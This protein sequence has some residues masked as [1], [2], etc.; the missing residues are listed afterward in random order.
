MGFELFRKNLSIINLIL[1]LW[2]ADF[3]RLVHLDVVR[4][5]AVL[6]SVYFPAGEEI[7]IQVE[8]EWNL[9]AKMQHILSKLH[10][11]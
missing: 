9:N 5:R 4:N 2:L 6:F 7:I 10:H 8:H 3:G 1:A 11:I